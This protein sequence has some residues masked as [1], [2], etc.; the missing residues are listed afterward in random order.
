MILGLARCHVTVTP[1]EVG[2]DVNQMRTRTLPPH[3]IVLDRPAISKIVHQRDI[4]R[5]DMV[6]TTDHA[7][8]EI[9]SRNA[10]AFERALRTM[11]NG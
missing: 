10:Q 3:I 6:C 4:V 11:V 1:Y 5:I 9:E 2:L 7:F 8:F